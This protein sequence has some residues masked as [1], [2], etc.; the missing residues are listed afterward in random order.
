MSEQYS[1]DKS[2]VFSKDSL[3]ELALTN[4]TKTYIA[5]HENIYDVTEFL[6]EVRKRT[7]WLLILKKA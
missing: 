3:F 1:S 7:I 5:I 6:D 2:K 4:T